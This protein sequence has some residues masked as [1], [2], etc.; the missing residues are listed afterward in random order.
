MNWVECT[1]LRPFHDE[2]GRFKTRHFTAGP[3]D[4]LS[5]LTLGLSVFGSLAPPRYRKTGSYVVRTCTRG[6]RVTVHGYTVWS[7]NRRQAHS[8][9]DCTGP[10]SPVAEDRAP[11]TLV[12]VTPCPSLTGGGGKEEGLGRLEPLRKSGPFRLVRGQREWERDP[13]FQGLG[14]KFLLRL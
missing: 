10:S 11:R 2:G 12:S 9:P 3:R 7:P 14:R 13:D 1:H 4:P 5:F 6:L 8:T